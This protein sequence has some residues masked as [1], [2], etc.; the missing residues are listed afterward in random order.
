MNNGPHGFVVHFTFHPGNNV[1]I[2]KGA[3]L[4]TVGFEML[5]LLQEFLKLRLELPGGNG[6]G[7]PQEFEHGFLNSRKIFHLGHEAEDRFGQ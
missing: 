2:G 7:M 4:E 6:D 3:G 1:E 5:D